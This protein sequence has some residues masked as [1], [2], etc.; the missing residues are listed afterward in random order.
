MIFAS[1][2]LYRKD[3]T[4]QTPF[5][6]SWCLS[7]HFYAILDIFPIP[8]VI[9]CLGRCFLL[10]FAVFCCF[11]LLFFVVIFFCFCFFYCFFVLP[12]FL[13]SEAQLD[14][15]WHKVYQNDHQDKGFPMVLLLS[16]YMTFLSIWFSIQPTTSRVLRHWYWYVRL[17]LDCCWLG[18]IHVWS[19]EIWILATFFV[20]DIGKMVDFGGWT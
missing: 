16:S 5:T 15:W 6:H 19:T 9:L 4:D 1:K 14:L 13:F 11:L 17:V 18:Y 7:R 2:T 12:F 3:T 10:F 20:G 8:T